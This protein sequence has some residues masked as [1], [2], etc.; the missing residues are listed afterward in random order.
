MHVVQLAASQ[1]LVLD[2]YVQPRFL[3]TEGPMVN[4]ETR[5]TIVMHRV[6]RWSLKRPREVLVVVDGLLAAQAW[7]RDEFERL[8]ND[9]SSLAHLSRNPRGNQ[10]IG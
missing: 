9:R 2:D 10:G 3:I 6:E 5:E 1:W 8:A 4:R 7:C